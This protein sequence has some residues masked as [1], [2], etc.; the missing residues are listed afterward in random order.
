MKKTDETCD[1]PG[2][3]QKTSLMGHT[4]TYCNHR[5]CYKHSLPESHSEKM[6]VKC[7][8]TVKKKERDEFLHPKIDT[9]SAKKKE[10]HDK[11]KK[12][13]DQKL[14]QMQFERKQKAPGAGSTSNKKK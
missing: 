1:Y 5:F 3:K 8:E 6:N 2:C 7:A 10:E 13:L 4:C 12:T 9:R 11:A 14:K